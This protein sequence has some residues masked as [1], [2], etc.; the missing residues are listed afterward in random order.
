MG[1]SHG[2]SAWLHPAI[3]LNLTA[4]VAIVCL[5]VGGVVRP[6]LASGPWWRTGTGAALLL[7]GLSSFLG[8]TGRAHRIVGVSVAVAAAF[9]I[10]WSLAIG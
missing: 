6:D 4:G 7:A 1:T 5:L 8:G 2:R 9:A 3:A 10:A